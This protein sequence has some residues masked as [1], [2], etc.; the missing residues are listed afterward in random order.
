MRMAKWK[1]RSSRPLS[2]RLCHRA[3]HERRRCWPRCWLL[4]LK[5]SQR[6]RGTRKISMRPSSPR[7]MLASVAQALL[8]AASAAW[9]LLGAASV[10]WA[11]AV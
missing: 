4:R 3:K 7:L 1:R 6:G 2:P 10:A 9:A 5:E 11:A 8:A